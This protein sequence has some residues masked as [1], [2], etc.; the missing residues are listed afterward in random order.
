MLRPLVGTNS[1]SDVPVFVQGTLGI[2]TGND[3]RCFHSSVEGL[4]PHIRRDNSYRFDENNV[5]VGQYRPFFKQRL[6][7]DRTVIHRIRKFAEIYPTPETENLGIYLTGAGSPVPFTTLLTNSIADIGLTSG[8]GASPYLPRYRYQNPD[9]ESLA[10]FHKGGIERVSNINPA[11][12]TEFRQHYN[13]ETISEDDLFYYSYGV[14]HSQ[15]WRDT[16]A[17]DLAKEAARIPMAGSAEDFHAFVDAGRELANL[18]VDYEN[19]EFYPLEEIQAGNWNPKA[20]DAYRVEK[21]KYAGKRPNLDTSTIHYNAGINLTGIPDEA[22]E[23]KLG[24]RSAIDWLIDRYQVRTHKKSGI[25]NDPNDWADEMGEPRY[26]LDLIKR[27]TTV[28][29]RTVEIVRGLPEL[30]I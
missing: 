20:P 5:R 11:A 28:S 13:D 14:L 27:V 7:F 12:L 18:H 10:D 8:N 25:V 24:T 3:A 4:R 23:Y 30:P 22:H 17:N 19:V 21:M 9:I 15:Q 29:V 26:I 6:Y 2:L 16:F 1:R